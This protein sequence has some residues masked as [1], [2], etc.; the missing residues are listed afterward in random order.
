M[1]VQ[2]EAERENEHDSKLMRHLVYLLLSVK[3]LTEY[4][5]REINTQAAFITRNLNDRIVTSPI[6]KAN[7]SVADV[8]SAVCILQTILLRGSCQ[9]SRSMADLFNILRSENNLIW[10]FLL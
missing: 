1:I 3:H 5:F 6:D 7:Q 9:I 10:L 8:I 2:A 4:V